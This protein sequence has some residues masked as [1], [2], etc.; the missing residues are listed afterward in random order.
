M[1]ETTEALV[2]QLESIRL[3]L[4]ANFHLTIAAIGALGGREMAQ[5]AQEGI[6]ALVKESDLL[7]EKARRLAKGM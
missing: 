6:S 5:E 1:S 7:A 3:E 4:R 2:S